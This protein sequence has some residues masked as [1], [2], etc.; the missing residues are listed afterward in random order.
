MKKF[1]LYFLVFLTS[2]E[3]LLSLFVLRLEFTIVKLHCLIIYHLKGILTFNMLISLKDS[4][5]SI[6]IRRFQIHCI[7][8]LY[9]TVQLP[10]SRL[11]K[12]YKCMSGILPKSLFLYA[13]LAG[14]SSAQIH[15]ESRVS[16]Y[17]KLITIIN[18]L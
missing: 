4:P 18:Y 8:L 10:T 1:T 5:I 15:V 3:R 14:Q 6:Q 17:L 13:I 12:N 9:F 11:L 2:P 7:M 16:L